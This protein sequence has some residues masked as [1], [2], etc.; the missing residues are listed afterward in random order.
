MYVV[1]LIHYNT[2]LLPSRFVK[3]PQG[4]FMVDWKNIFILL[5]V[6]IAQKIEVV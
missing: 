1:Y 6:I 4:V 2:F 3:P 5:R